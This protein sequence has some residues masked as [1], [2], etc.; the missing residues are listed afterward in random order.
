MT[1]KSLY[2]RLGGAKGIAALVDGIV[3][4]HMA[5][6]IIKARFLPY[7]DKPDVV[8]RVKKHTCDFLGSGTGGPETYAGRSMSDTHRGMNIT[9][10]EYAAVAEDIL[11][12]L[13]KHKID[14]QTRDEVM[15]IVGSLK[16]EIVGV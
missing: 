16:S 2:E 13:K 3:D 10:Q 6:P 4:A 8:E 11:A 7:A 14:S 15:S 1:N 9:E 12:T 5:K